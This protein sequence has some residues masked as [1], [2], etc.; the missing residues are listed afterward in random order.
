[1]VTPDNNERTPN[2]AAATNH[3]PAGDK[4]NHNFECDA[5][6]LY[7]CW[8]HGLSK[9]PKNTS[10]SCNAPGENHRTDATL[11]NRMGGR[12]KINF[13]HSGKQRRLEV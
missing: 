1:M 13:G 11:E 12:N 4:A 9:N 6:K 10:A 2:L 5:I 7:Y 8:T 3:P